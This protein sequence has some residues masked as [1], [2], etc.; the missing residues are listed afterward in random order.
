M[1]TPRNYSVM[2]RTN[3]F[4][5][6][7]GCTEL[8]LDSLSRERMRERE[9][10]STRERKKGS[11]LKV[12]NNKTSLKASPFN[13]LCCVGCWTDFFCF[14]S[15][16]GRSVLGTYTLGGD[17]PGS[18]GEME[19]KGENAEVAV[20]CPLGSMV[21][22]G[23]GPWKNLEQKVKTPSHILNRPRKLSKIR[24]RPHT[25]V[26]TFTRIH[27]TCLSHRIPRILSVE[28]WIRRCFEAFFNDNLKTNRVRCWVFQF[29]IRRRQLSSSIRTPPGAMGPL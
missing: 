27:A 6:P 24:T 4:L 22:L 26:H 17:I 3:I 29:Y 19:R 18:A 10:E 7:S 28:N 8:K 1:P 16:K 5:K 20:Q 9:R 23:F 15:S 12:Y 11:D 13:T 14:G 2:T 25:H 21:G